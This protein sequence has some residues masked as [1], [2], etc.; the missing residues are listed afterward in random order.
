[1]VKKIKALISGAGFGTRLYP[2]TKD[3]AKPLLEIGGKAIIN[4]MIY[5]DG[6]FCKYL[7]LLSQNLQQPH[8]YQQ[9]FS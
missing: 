9:V 4:H 6:D 1:M 8:P 3:K 5:P 7:K 2:L